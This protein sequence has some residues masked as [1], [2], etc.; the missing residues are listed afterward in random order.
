M[1]DVNA[2]EFLN[3][4]AATEQQPVTVNKKKG[5]KRWLWLGVLAAGW[6]LMGFP[7]SSDQVLYGFSAGSECVQFAQQRAKD[8]GWNLK[9]IAAGD[10]WFKKGRVVVELIATDK[11]ATNNSNSRNMESRLCVVGG[12]MVSLPGLFENMGWR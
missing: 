3:R 10:V 11:V 8:I 1:T 4:A 7:T 2:E 12:G 5:H 9:D 6:A